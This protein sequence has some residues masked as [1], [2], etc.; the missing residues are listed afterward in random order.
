MSGSELKQA[1]KKLIVNRE[2]SP[3]GTYRG[4]IEDANWETFDYSGLKALPW[5]LGIGGKSKRLKR[6]QF[7]GAI[8]ENVVIGAAAVHV[9]YLGTGFAYVYDRKSNTITEKNIKSPL[10]RNTSFS[11][12]PVTGISEIIKGAHSIRAENTVREGRRNL[13]VDFGS[14]L[15]FSIDYDEPGFGVSTI[16]PQDGAGFHHTYKSAGLPATGEYTLN[17]NTTPLTSNALAL[18]DW[19]ISTP[20]R[21]T[22]WNW[23]CAVGRDA[24]G[25]PI[26]INCSRGLVGGVYSQNTIWLDGRPT[27]LSGVSF[28]YDSGNI[29][30][31]P[32][33]VHTSD[34][35]LDLTFHP[36]S[37]RFENI[38]LG[39]VASRLHQPFGTYKGV[40][41]A[42]GKIMEVELFGFC[43]EHYAKW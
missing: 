16:C 14:G 41:K 29:P 9:Q 39:L 3:Y 23:A 36:L 42:E 40:L 26:G 38:N 31:H 28:D 15:S 33:H 8:D 10:A 32:W 20:P 35:N 13:H 17:G 30:G 1:P 24:S 11:R 27:V 7:V 2:A 37:E 25:L 6:W 21:A 4:A 5:P 22:T 18:L 12:S 34:G 43:E 19:T